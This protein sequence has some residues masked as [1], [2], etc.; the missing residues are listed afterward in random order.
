MAFQKI[1][2]SHKKELVHLVFQSSQRLTKDYDDKIYYSIMGGNKDSA[3]ISIETKEKDS[4]IED[5]QV[6]QEFINED[7]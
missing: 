7:L 6:E 5:N 2:A 1:K 3:G 4:N